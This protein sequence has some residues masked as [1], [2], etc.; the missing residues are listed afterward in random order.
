MREHLDRK[1]DLFLDLWYLLW[2]LNVMFPLCDRSREPTIGL[3]HPNDL[4]LENKAI[5]GFLTI[6]SEL[7]IRF[8]CVRSIL[9]C[10]YLVLQGMFIHPMAQKVNECHYD[11]YNCG[12]EWLNLFLSIDWVV[13]IVVKSIGFLFSHVKIISCT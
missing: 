12:Y 13:S 3:H 1:Y 10:S 7:Y 2:F 4:K 9:G 8:L 5:W 11:V 6:V